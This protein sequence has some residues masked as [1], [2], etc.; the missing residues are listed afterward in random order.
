[1]DK[2]LGYAEIC[3]IFSAGVIFHILLFG[4]GLFKGE[5]HS[6]ILKLNK[7][8]EINLTLKIYDTID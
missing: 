4:E 8:C 1:M 2:T 5:S 7:I 6:E 3:D